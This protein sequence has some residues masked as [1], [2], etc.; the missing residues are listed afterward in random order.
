[1]STKIFFLN[2]RCL[3]DLINRIQIKDHRIGTFYQNFFVM[4]WRQNIHP[5]YR[6]DGLPL[7]YQSQLYEK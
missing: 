1:M 6:V 3:K 4:L 2:K 5:K 7:V